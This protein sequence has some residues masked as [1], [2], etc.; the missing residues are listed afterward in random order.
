MTTIEE[1]IDFVD[2]VVGRD[3]FGDARRHVIGLVVDD[4]V[5][6][7]ASVTEPVARLS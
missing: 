3:P 1:Q 5:F 6:R 7:F 4:R 2:I